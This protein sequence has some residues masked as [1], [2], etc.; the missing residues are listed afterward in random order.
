M[1][2]EPE[3]LPLTLRSPSL[4]D[5][6]GDDKTEEEAD[7]YSIES[8]ESE[9]EDKDGERT[10]LDFFPILS[11]LLDDLLEFFEEAFGLRSF[12]LLSLLCL[13]LDKY[14]D[15]DETLFDF[16]KDSA[17]DGDLFSHLSFDFCNL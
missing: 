13:P 6:V 1:D 7:E 17:T 16:F 14:L 8:A 2:L 10:I 15:D 11:L 4:E 3:G 12:I 5:D 9:D